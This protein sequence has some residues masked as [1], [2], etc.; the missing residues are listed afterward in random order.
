MAF[1]QKAFELAQYLAEELALRTGLASAT[2]FEADQSPFVQLGSGAIGAAGAYIRVKP[3]SSLFTNIVGH[4]Q[5]VFTPHVIQVCFEA[6]VAALGVITDVTTLAQ[7][8]QIL[9]PLLAKG[10]R[11]EVYE[12]ANGVAP[13]AAT[14]VAGNL[15]TSIEPTLQYPMVSNQ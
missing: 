13:A 10:T 1:T 4:T 5:D 3:L 15:K 11:V 6:P 2:G 8:A 14:L 7:K 12:N 9:T